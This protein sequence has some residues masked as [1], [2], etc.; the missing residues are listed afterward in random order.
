MARRKIPIRIVVPDATPFVKLS[1]IG[2]LDLLDLFKVP[3]V[4]VDQ[5][6]HE[7]RGGSHDQTSALAGWLDR[8]ANRIEVVSTEI[9]ET[10][11]KAR[12]VDPDHPAGNLGERAVEEYA[13]RYARDTPKTYV[14]L[15]L[16]EDSDVIADTELPRTKGVHLV[17]IRAWLGTLKRLGIVP[18]ADEILE[19]LLE[20]GKLNPDYE[21]PARTKDVEGV[22]AAPQ[23][24][25][26][27]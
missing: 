2:R 23:P 1:K 6:A 24:R 14:P 27:L 13:R 26:V 17:N 16:F 19:D 21:K 8:N 11:R 20:H 5:V 12:L 9:G 3:I 7:M 25:G 18:D 22:W 4:V 15:V 10:F